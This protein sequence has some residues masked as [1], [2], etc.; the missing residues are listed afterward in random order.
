MVSNDLLL[1]TNF[2]F[3]DFQCNDVHT[4]RYEN[5]QSTKGAGTYGGTRGK[6]QAFV[7]TKRQ[8]S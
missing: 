3:N 1:W 4:H 8:V 6:H 7:H 5:L 2:T